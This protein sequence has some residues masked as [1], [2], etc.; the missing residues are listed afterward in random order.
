MGRVT[1][2]VDGE[3]TTAEE[4]EFYDRLRP[5]VTS[6][7]RADPVRRVAVVGNQPLEPSEE[8]A[9][10]IDSADVVFRVNGFR[11]DEAG[12]PPAVGRRADVVVFNRGVRP[13][14]WFFESYTERAYLM[15]EPGRLLWENPKIPEFWPA[16]LGIV[17]MPNREVVLPLGEAM[18]ADP[19]SGGHWAT[20]G[21]VMLWIATRLFPDAQVDASGFSFIDAPDQTAWNH[22]YGD[23]SAVGAEHRIELESVLVKR[24]IESGRVTYRH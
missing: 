21:T 6:Y 2:L 11:L 17:T 18:G 14:P 1:E 22:A 13:T 12:G 19:R 10:I 9:A 23:P 16:D 3:K 4:A 15:I 5:L 8:R 24:W 20:T 7:G